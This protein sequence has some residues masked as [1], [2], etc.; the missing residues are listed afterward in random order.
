M[1][2]LV[3][4]PLSAF[5]SLSVFHLLGD[6]YGMSSW[7]QDDITWL[8]P[9]LQLARSLWWGGCRW[10]SGGDLDKMLSGLG[11]GQSLVERF[12]EALPMEITCQQSFE[13]W[14][15]DFAHMEGAGQRAFRQRRREG[16]GRNMASVGNHRKL[17]TA[18]GRAVGWDVKWEGKWFWVD[19]EEPGALLSGVCIFSWFGSLAILFCQDKIH[20]T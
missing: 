15:D 18:Q 4:L 1:R 7:H 9:R 6:I 16:A 13:D 14:V 12:G 3:L 5:V 20:I 17:L 10:Q 8:R 2:W 11:G 19:P